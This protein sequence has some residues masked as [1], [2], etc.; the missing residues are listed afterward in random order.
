MKAQL[1]F[2]A[3]CPTSLLQ[4]SLFMG[5]GYYSYARAWTGSTYGSDHTDLILLWKKDQRRRYS[6]VLDC[7]GFPFSLFIVHIF[8]EKANRIDQRNEMEGGDEGIERVEDSKD[9]QQQSK[10]FDKLTDRVEDRQ[11]D[12]TRVQ[13]VLS[14]SFSVFEI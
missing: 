7:A 10:A 5:L 13:E 12:S 2:S 9:L 4:C 8:R 3:Q 6:R 11:L 1:L 14:F